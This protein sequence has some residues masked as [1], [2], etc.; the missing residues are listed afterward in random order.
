MIVTSYS[1]K[2]RTNDGRLEDLKDVPYHEANW[3]KN[4]EEAIAWLERMN[5]ENEDLFINDA[6]FLEQLYFTNS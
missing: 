3:F 2:S 6:L 4:R 5:K 1:W